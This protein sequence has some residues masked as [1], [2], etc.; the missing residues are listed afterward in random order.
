MR[1]QMIVHSI[2]LYLIVL[3]SRLHNMLFQ[4]FDLTNQ[5]KCDDDYNNRLTLTMCREN[6]AV[7]NIVYTITSAFSSCSRYCNRQ[8]V[9]RK[10]SVIL[11]GIDPHST[12]V[13]ATLLQHCNN[14]TCCS[15]IVE[16]LQQYCCK[17]FAV[18]E[19]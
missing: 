3:W 19:Q 12:K 14:I 13:A 18:W 9:T 7:W 5:H 4:R 1:S 11:A 6:A 10:S 2:W 15:N 17:F 16:I 8:L